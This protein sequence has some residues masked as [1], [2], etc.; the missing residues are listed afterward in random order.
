MSRELLLRGLYRG[1]E[2]NG[3]PVHQF[4]EQRLSGAFY[5]VTEGDGSYGAARHEFEQ[6]HTEGGAYRW[7]KSSPV[8]AYRADVSC[9]VDTVVRD[10]Q[11]RRLER[12]VIAD[13]THDFV[14]DRTVGA[15]PVGV[16]LP[17]LHQLNRGRPEA[18][19][20]ALHETLVEV[21]L[22]R[23]V[24]TLDLVNEVSPG[25]P[26]RANVSPEQREGV[27]RGVVG[28][29]DD[30][31]ATRYPSLRVGPCAVFE[32]EH[33]AMTRLV[34]GALSAPTRVRVGQ[35]GVEAVG[36]PPGRG[37]DDAV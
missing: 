30:A 23:H 14:D 17:H 35:R 31:S 5:A 28:A 16:G 7:V 25:P 10:E 1:P 4:G 36:D 11:D 18:A 21:T 33:D 3:P 9:V 22:P 37:I 27:T 24:T 20:E 34:A 15:G 29:F 8:L 2:A 26:S 13:S 12:L 6:T 32:V 19:G